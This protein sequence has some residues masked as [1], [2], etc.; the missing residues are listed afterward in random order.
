MED[1][2]PIRPSVFEFAKAMEATLEENDHKGGWMDF[3]DV[4]EIIKDREQNGI[5]TG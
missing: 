1:T 5:D 4:Q 3:E 2:R